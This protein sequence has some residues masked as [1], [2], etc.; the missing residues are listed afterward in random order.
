MA[1]SIGVSIVSIILWIVGVRTDAAVN[2]QYF[3]S[4][5]EA[6]QAVRYKQVAVFPVHASKR[7]I[8]LTQ[9]GY[10]AQCIRGC[11][12]T[13][14]AADIGAP[15]GTEVMAAVSGR[16]MDVDQ[17]TLAQSKPSGAS[18]RIKGSDGLWY[19]Y[20][21]M[22]VS[23]ARPEVGQLVRAGD[24]IGVVGSKEDA[25]GTAPHLHFDIS[26]IDNGFSRG[27]SLCDD[28]CHSLVAPQPLL[29]GAYAKLPEN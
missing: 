5:A 19:Y 27:T 9:V 16:V 6:K 20:T 11:H 2:N 26:T 12:Y 24:A 22:R 29:W 28:K 3:L 1:I 13:Y 25:Q 15:E 7:A 18:I 8:Q 14:E 4:S 21:H 17:Q 23:S 10:N